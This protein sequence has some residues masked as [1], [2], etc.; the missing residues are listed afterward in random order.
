MGTM[1]TEHQ[2]EQAPQEHQLM[3]WFQGG[4]LRTVE[5]QECVTAFRVLAEGL[6]RNLPNSAEKTVALRKLMESK[7][8]AIRAMIEAELG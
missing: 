3:R 6:D 2:P 7:D 5:L 4:H 8:A 1:S